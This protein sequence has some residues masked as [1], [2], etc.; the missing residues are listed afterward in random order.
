MCERE[1]TSAKERDSGL[2]CVCV[3]EK[4]SLRDECER[5]IVRVRSVNERELA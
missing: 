2:G 1:R 5:G 3:R 4:D